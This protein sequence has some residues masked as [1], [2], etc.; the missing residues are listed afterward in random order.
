MERSDFALDRSRTYKHRVYAGRA[1][2]L[3]TYAF[4]IAALDDN[5][6]NHAHAEQPY[7]F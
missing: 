2:E 1:V 3:T 7:V 6:A 4:E 5:S